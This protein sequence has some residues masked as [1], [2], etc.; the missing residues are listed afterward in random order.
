M[1][2]SHLVRFAVATTT[3]VNKSA[4]L[5][6]DLYCEYGIPFMSHQCAYAQLADALS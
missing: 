5:T 1:Q 6:I 2:V 4:I 3:V